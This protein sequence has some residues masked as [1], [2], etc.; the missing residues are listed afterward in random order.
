MIDKFEFSFFVEIFLYDSKDWNSGSIY[1]FNIKQLR[2]SP[3][4]D[5]KLINLQNH[6]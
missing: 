6:F 2:T 3:E 5:M 1:N 4:G